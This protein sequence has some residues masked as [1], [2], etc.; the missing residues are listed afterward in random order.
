MNPKER[1]LKLEHINLCI[2]ADEAKL[3]QLNGMGAAR[4][5]EKTLV[6]LVYLESQFN[7][8]NFC[9]KDFEVYNIGPFLK[10]HYLPDEHRDAP[11]YGYEPLAKYPNLR[12]PISLKIS[13]QKI[14]HL[15]KAMIPVGTIVCND[16][17][18]NKIDITRQDPI[19]LPVEMYVELQTVRK[20]LKQLKEQ[21]AALLPRKVQ[22]R[23]QTQKQKQKQQTKKVWTANDILAM[24]NE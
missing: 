4:F 3:Y 20:R 10:F 2:H 22:Q 9:G 15:S 18:A 21:K 23:Q 5:R 11:T 16:C 7:P 8:C 1:R 13:Y 14:E 17:I 19:T 12:I 24:F 6:E